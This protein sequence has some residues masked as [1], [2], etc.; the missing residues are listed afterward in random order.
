MEG[1]A[2]EDG[3]RWDGANIGG[4]GMVLTEEGEGGEEEEKRKSSRGPVA[5][6]IYL[7]LHGP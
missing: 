6:R 7:F 3:G 2:R 5:H 1:V 4:G